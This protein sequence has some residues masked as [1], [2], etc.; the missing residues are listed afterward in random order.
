V[1]SLV[2]SDE[3]ADH[4]SHKAAAERYKHSSAGNGSG[5]SCASAE[6]SSGG[7][8]KVL[9]QNE[10]CPTAGAEAVLEFVAYF[11]DF[12]RDDVEMVRTLDRAL[13]QRYGPM[14]P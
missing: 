9:R 4:Y 14:T 5:L 6:R 10:A 7:S 12:V 13:K 8:T 11:Y 2:V 3:A 1:Y